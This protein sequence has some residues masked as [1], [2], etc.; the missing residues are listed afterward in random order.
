MLVLFLLLALVFPAG[1]WTSR[2]AEASALGNIGS[3]IK[4][5]ETEKKRLPESWNE[6][7]ELWGNPLDQTFRLVLPT[8]R[9][10]LFSP[11]LDL[12]IHEKLSM[13]VVAITRKPMWETTRKG[14][15]GRTIA[16]KGP[17]RYV[18]YREED[19]DLFIRW[20]DES[21]IQRLWPST[22]QALPVPDQEPER[23]WVT[24]AR[25]AIMVKRIG[26]IVLVILVVAWLAGRIFL[27]RREAT[28]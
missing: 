12:R 19:G 10:E 28:A 17:G 13:R 9:Y 1:A 16:L 23:P 2:T 7:E 5:F 6:L 20:F 25:R 18:L 14:N 4:H 11:P 21:T 24:N 22:G 26:L 15:M 27:K 3:F 8:R